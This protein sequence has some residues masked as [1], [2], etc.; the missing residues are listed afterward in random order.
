MRRS[1]FAQARESRWARSV[2]TD[3]TH[4][5]DKLLVGLLA[6][7]GYLRA[8]AGRFRFGF[9]LC[10]VAVCFCLVLLGLALASEVVATGHR[11]DGFL[12]PALGVLDDALHRFSRSRLVGVRHGSVPPH[13]R[14]WLSNSCSMPIDPAI[15][16][17]T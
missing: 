6:L 14:T 8:T 17:V 9:L 10:R 4:P 15:G 13:W 2:F 3:R 7:L 11:T 16:P 5:S 12:G 1:R